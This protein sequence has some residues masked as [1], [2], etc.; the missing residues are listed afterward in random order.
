[1]PAS[2]RSSLLGLAAA[3]ALSTVAHANTLTVLVGGGNQ[4]DATIAAYVAPFEKETGIK[5]NAVKQQCAPAVVRTMVQSNR[6]DIDIC[7]LSGASLI[8]LAREGML[9]PLD[10]NLISAQTIKEI[11][12]EVV[13]EYGIGAYNYAITL[14]FDRAKYSKGHPPASWKDFWDVKQ[15]PGTRVLQSGAY[16]NQ[17]PW[18]EA[19][20][21]DGVPADKLYPIDVDRALKSLDKLKPAVRKWWMVGSE[22]EQLFGSGAA[23]GQGFD[24]IF[25]NM[26]KTN[27]NIAY[28]YNQAK[29]YSLHLTIPKG[30]QN[31]AAA[32][33]FIDFVLKDKPQAEFAKLSGYSPTNKTAFKLLDPALASTLVGSPGNRELAYYSNAKWYAEVGPSGK[34]NA[35]A[36]IQRWNEWVLK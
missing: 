26:M 7:M 11:E 23:A 27:K 10:Y 35:E 21:A 17:G 4:A 8:T 18:E 5:V 16:P 36:L 33:K 28:V 29:M 14:G 15:F 31:I 34:T 12:R 3:L 9:T 22:Q 6:H 25:Q 30:S 2:L 20:L 19:L 13:H 32:H 1:M 24:G